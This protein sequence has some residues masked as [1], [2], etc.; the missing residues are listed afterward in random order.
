MVMDAAQSRIVR[1]SAGDRN[2]HIFYAFLHGATAEEKGLCRS[3]WPTRG[4]YG[5]C[6]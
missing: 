2:Y 1:L 6:R 5:L 4:L 3:A